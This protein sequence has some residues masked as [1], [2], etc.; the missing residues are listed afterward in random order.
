MSTVNFPPKL[1][2]TN[3]SFIINS[4]PN[5]SVLKKLQN[6]NPPDPVNAISTLHKY[7]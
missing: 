1:Y 7:V 5:G 6:L 2:L 4:E 3:V